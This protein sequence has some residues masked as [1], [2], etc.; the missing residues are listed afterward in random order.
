[1]LQPQGVRPAAQGLPYS[2]CTWETATDLDACESGGARVDEFLER[3]L[4]IREPSVG[5]DAAQKTFKAGYREMHQ[6]PDFL[7]GTYR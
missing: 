7:A 4:R 6:Q 5:V 3:E 1:M 2:E